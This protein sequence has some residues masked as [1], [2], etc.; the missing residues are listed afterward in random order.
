MTRTYV[1]PE[2]TF[3]P[4]TGEAETSRRSRRYIPLS[5]DTRRPGI[6]DTR[7]EGNGRAAPA[8]K[9]STISDLSP[10]T[11]ASEAERLVTANLPAT[12][13]PVRL[14]EALPG[15]SEAASCAAI[16]EAE[17]R[18]FPG[19]RIAPTAL[20]VS[21]ALSGKAKGTV[22]AKSGLRYE[23]VAV[24]SGLSVAEVRKL[25]SE[26]IDLSA[27]Y[28]GGTKKGTIYEGTSERP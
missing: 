9:G 6:V 8:T 28:I 3:V 26:K 16:Y 2:R 19:L 11:V 13:P 21:R 14:R 4:R 12:T 1:W 22:A 17:Y 15:L 24:R 27:R 20:A 7:G 10:D 25:A 23:R 5:G 18:L